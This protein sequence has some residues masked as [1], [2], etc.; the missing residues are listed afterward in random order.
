MPLVILTL[1]LLKRPAD[2]AVMRLSSR[3]YEALLV[4]AVSL[5]LVQAYFG[6]E[7]THGTSH[8]MF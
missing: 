5:I 3:A 4:V 2:Q 1:W 8:M 6:A 7:V